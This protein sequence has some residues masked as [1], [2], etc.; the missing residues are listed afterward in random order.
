MVPHI[1]RDS[2]HLDFFLS[3]V[4]PIPM[5]YLMRNAFC[6]QV[7]SCP[8]VSEI[9]DSHIHSG[10]LLELFQSIDIDCHATYCDGSFARTWSRAWKRESWF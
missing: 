3:S 6:H 1:H 2:N 5:Q 4:I 8:V 10:F 7:R 9:Q